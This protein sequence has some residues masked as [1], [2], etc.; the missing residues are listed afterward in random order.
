MT[1]LSATLVGTVVLTAVMAIGYPNEFAEIAGLFILVLIYSGLVCAV[2]TAILGPIAIFAS[3]FFAR[4]RIWR[5]FLI[6][7]TALLPTFV[8]TILGIADG[9]GSEAVGLVT[10]PYTVTA[11]LVL[12][13][14]LHREP[15]NAATP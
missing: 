13:W 9:N 1:A 11:G 2:W 12:W 4:D 5:L 3:W 10:A 6:M 15:P 7:L 8:Y 14:W